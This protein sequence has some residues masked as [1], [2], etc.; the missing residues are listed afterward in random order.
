M[1]ATSFKI[2]GPGMNF[3]RSEKTTK[4]TQ[5]Y[6]KKNIEKCQPFPNKLPKIPK[7]Y[8]QMF[9]VGYLGL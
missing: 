6:S 4:S 8:R 9:Y 5:H 2:L 3:K 7:L 1:L